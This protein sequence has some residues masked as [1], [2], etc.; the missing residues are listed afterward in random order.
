MEGGRKWTFWSQSTSYTALKL[1]C[2]TC[3]LRD[4][5]TVNLFYKQLVKKYKRKNRA[6]GVVFGRAPSLCSWTIWLSW[7]PITFIRQK[8]LHNLASSICVVFA[9]HIFEN[10]FV[11][12]GPLEMAKMTIKMVPSKRLKILFLVWPIRHVDHIA[13]SSGETGKAVNPSQE[14]WI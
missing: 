9:G 7:R 12:D 11:F 10:Q 6:S 8:S 4:I 14:S 13:C 5:C 1:R 2:G 3:S